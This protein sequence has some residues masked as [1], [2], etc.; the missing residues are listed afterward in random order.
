MKFWSAGC[1]GKVSMDCDR[2]QGAVD[3]CVLNLVQGCTKRFFCLCV[4]TFFYL[5]IYI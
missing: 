2:S 1:P 4:S 5:Y 3:V